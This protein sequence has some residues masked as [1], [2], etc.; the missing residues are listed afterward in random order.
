M[1]F[2]WFDLVEVGEA[3]YTGLSRWLQ[4]PS[5]SFSFSNGGNGPKGALTVKVAQWWARVSRAILAEAGY[6]WLWILNKRSPS[7]I[8]SFSVVECCP[9]VFWKP[10][11]LGQ[12]FRVSAVWG[13]FLL[14]LIILYFFFLFGDFCFFGG[15]EGFMAFWRLFRWFYGFLME[16]W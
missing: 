13:F 11:G 6:L 2:Y 4:A 16:I 15:K 5:C 12:L 1:I 3:L 7:L 10:C 14:F 8:Y 9:M